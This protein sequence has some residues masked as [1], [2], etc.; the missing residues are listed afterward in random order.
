MPLQL[1]VAF[2]LKNGGGTETATATATV[3]IPAAL[4]F[5][6][7]SQHGHDRSGAITNET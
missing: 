2:Q 3:F 1:S 5:N 7:D 6:Q 4:S